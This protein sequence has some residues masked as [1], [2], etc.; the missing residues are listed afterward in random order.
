M[1]RARLPSRWMLE[2][3]AIATVVGVASCSEPEYVT[4]PGTDAVQVLAVLNPSHPE[5]IIIVE[6]VRTGRDPIPQVPFNPADPIATGHGI[7]VSNARVVIR[8]ETGDSMVALE[9]LGTKRTGAGVYRFR[10]APSA[11]GGNRA[12]RVVPGRS[13]TLH[14]TTLEGHQL[15]GVTRVPNATPAAL[16]TGR[17]EPFDR[18]AEFLQL[19]WPSVSDSKRYL[20]SIENPFREFS[21]LTSD[22]SLVITGALRLLTE[23]FGYVFVP[24]FEQSVAAVAVDENLYDWVRSMPPNDAASRS[25][26]E[27]GYGLFGSAVLLATRSVYVTVRDATAPTALWVVNTGTASSS[28]VPPYIRLFSGPRSNDV[29]M[30]SG[31][32]METP[33]GQRRGILGMLRGDSVHLSLLRGWS[34]RD[35]VARL[36]GIVTGTTMQLSLRGTATSASY[37]QQ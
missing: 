17:P 34:A 3:L 37:T 13:Y 16:P 15:R 8:A 26:I 18:D 5:Q 2:S 14:V 7:P 31:N 21:A 19:S 33:N 23:G 29:T 28:G 36:D 22:T 11:S 10:S 6:R 35:T 9:D 4:S 30:L 32:Y 24:G 1:M 25:H 27:G 20:L 12:L